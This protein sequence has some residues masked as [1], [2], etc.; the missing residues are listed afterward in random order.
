MS[1]ESF[2][3]NEIKRKYLKSCLITRINLFKRLVL[4]FLVFS[5]G[6]ISK[7]KSI[8]LIVLSVARLATVHVQVSKIY[9]IPFICY[10]G[11]RDV[12][13]MGL[14]AA[15]SRLHGSPSAPRPT[16]PGAGPLHRLP[17]FP[18]KV[19]RSVTPRPFY[20]LLQVS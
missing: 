15:P 6:W 13:S 14:G 12:G 19:F 3:A 4:P 16:V 1:S 10:S 9:V 11:A 8:I 20:C 17:S 18:S 5:L 7:R 2:P